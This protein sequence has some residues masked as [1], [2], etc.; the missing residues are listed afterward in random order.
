MLPSCIACQVWLRADPSSPPPPP[1]QQAP[2]RVKVL[3]K[4]ELRTEAAA[5]SGGEQGSGG[6]CPLSSL[7]EG[8]HVKAPRSLA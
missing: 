8:G 1:A 5:L 3:L 6:P 7:P 2:L 4:K